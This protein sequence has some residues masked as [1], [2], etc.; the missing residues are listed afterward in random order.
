MVKKGSGT[1]VPDNQCDLGARDLGN[2]SGEGGGGTVVDPS[3]GGP[4]KTL[5]T[6]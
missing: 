6:V 5:T 3:R 1:L 2:E 4:V